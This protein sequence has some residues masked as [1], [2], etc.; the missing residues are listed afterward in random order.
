[1]IPRIDNKLTSTKVALVGQSTLFNLWNVPKGAHSGSS[2]D[3]SCTES[4]TE[5][6]SDISIV[7]A[8]VEG[9]SIPRTMTTRSRSTQQASQKERKKEVLST[10]SA[11]T[12]KRKRMM[13]TLGAYLFHPSK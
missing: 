5:A 9:S 13:K 4:D 2:H 7:R 12:S 1:M 10:V 8:D 3:V 11:Q 6:P